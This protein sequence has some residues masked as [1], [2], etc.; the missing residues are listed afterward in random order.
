MEQLL[1][2][3]DQLLPQPL[4]V[5]TDG[6]HRKLFET[7]LVL[8]PVLLESHHVGVG[9]MPEIEHLTILVLRPHRYFF[10]FLREFF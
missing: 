3:E 7:P 4:A 1:A 8:L 5:V 2:A 6:K 9:A 10:V